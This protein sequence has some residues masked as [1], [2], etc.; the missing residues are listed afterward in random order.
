MKG[1]F[2][3]LSIS[4]AGCLVLA[5]VCSLVVA[6]GTALAVKPGETHWFSVDPQE[7]RN[8]DGSI[9][10]SDHGLFIEGAWGG[11]DAAGIP[12]VTPI[13]NLEGRAEDWGLVINR[14]SLAIEL[15]MLDG[16]KDDDGDE[17][18]YTDDGPFRADLSIRSGTR[19]HPSPVVICYF[20]AK[21]K[22]GKQ[23]AY[24][25]WSEDVTIEGP[26]ED[27]DGMNFP[28]GVAKWQTYTIKILDT[29]TWFLQQEVGS[30]KAAYEGSVT[31]GFTKIVVQRTE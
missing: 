15:S 27:P 3:F 29:S 24:R 23:L 5:A 9:D 21:G 10:R 16:W 20:W 18:I 4:V 1:R 14:P 6:P 26:P 19:R 17:W 30:R 31:G 28:L 2:E 11:V 22:S 12:I 8:G 13:A 7:D 25:L